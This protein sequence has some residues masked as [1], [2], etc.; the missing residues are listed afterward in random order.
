MSSDAESLR[1]F[2]VSKTVSR[3][4]YAIAADRDLEVHM[5]RRVEAL[6]HRARFELAD[7]AWGGGKQLPRRAEKALRKFIEIV[8]GR[9]RRAGVATP[10]HFDEVWKTVSGSLAEYCRRFFRWLDPGVECNPVG[11]KPT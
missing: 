11:E 7:V 9:M 5:T 10:S 4:K 6:A 8:V 1:D 2:F 3:L